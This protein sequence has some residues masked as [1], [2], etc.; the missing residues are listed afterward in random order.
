MTDSYMIYLQWFNPSVFCWIHLAALCPWVDNMTI[1]SVRCRVQ[2]CYSSHNWR[3][4]SSCWQT[5]R[6]EVTLRYSKFG[7]YLASVYVRDRL[8]PVTHLSP[9]L[10]SEFSKWQYTAYIWIKTDV[11]LKVRAE[12]CR[13][14]PLPYFLLLECQHHLD[15]DEYDQELVQNLEGRPVAYDKEWTA[16][17]TG[18]LWLFRSFALCCA[19]V[20]Q[21]HHQS[22]ASAGW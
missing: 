8:C 11:W 21:N 5:N 10:N 9:R 15:A 20:R 18:R 7:T 17:Q 3:Y 1:K 2:F 22:G 12:I 16:S 13:Y 14:W 19:Q 4:I 6:A